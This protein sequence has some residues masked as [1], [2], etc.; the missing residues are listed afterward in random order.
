MNRRLRWIGILA[1]AAVATLPASAQ[2]GTTP[3]NVLDLKRQPRFI[4]L[5]EAMAIAVEK[6]NTGGMASE[7]P[8]S[9]AKRR[10]SWRA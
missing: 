5:K 1:F 9:R 6:G 2:V 3:A 10:R 4:S 7:A 8:Q